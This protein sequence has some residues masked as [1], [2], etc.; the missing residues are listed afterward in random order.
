MHNGSSSGLMQFCSEGWVTDCIVR[1]N[2]D[3]TG[4]AH[5]MRLLVN[6]DAVYEELTFGRTN[7][8][9]SWED[10]MVPRRGNLRCLLRPLNGWTAGFL[11][12]LFTANWPSFS[13]EA[14]SMLILQKANRLFCLKSICGRKKKKLF[15]P[16]LLL[17]SEM[18][19]GAINH[20]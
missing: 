15:W 11:R 12:H 1:L 10:K 20:Q 2:T 13:F 17:C 8:S 4:Y 7:P 16:F 18:L 3:N 19:P 14:T 5:R 6:D 9:A